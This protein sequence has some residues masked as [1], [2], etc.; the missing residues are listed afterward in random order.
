MHKM[1]MVLHRFIRMN[2]IAMHCDTHKIN[3]SIDIEIS[4]NCKCVTQ[5]NCL[6]FVSS[7]SP[8]LSK[9]NGQQ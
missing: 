2:E 3:H 4:D 1:Q 7:P 6:L 5:F 8:H 9:Q